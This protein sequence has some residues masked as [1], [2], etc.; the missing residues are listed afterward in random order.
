M[1]CRYTTANDHDAQQGRT[2]QGAEFVTRIRDIS[3]EHDHDTDAW[4]TLTGTYGAFVLV[5]QVEGTAEWIEAQQQLATSPAYRDL[6]EA[7]ST[8]IAQPAHGTSEEIVGSAGDHDGPVAVST[9]TRVTLLGGHLS[10]AMGWGMEVLDLVH[11][12]SGLS[13]AFT[14]TTAGAIH[15]I[16]FVLRARSGEEL[17]QADKK[18]TA[19]PRYT[20]LVDRV[21]PSCVPGSARRSVLLQLP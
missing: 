5:S 16:G 7:A 6:L 21:G 12:V 8:C 13:C 10:D 15:D 2:D 11:E 1:A 14:R 20:N 4:V 19:D 17:D 18:L 9:V 3:R